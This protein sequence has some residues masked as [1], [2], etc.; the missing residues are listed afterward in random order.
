M[1][2][3]G[4]TELLKERHYIVGFIVQFLYCELLQWLRGVEGERSVLTPPHFPSSKSLTPSTYINMFAARLCSR[5]AVA[6]PMIQP[7]AAV[8]PVFAVRSFQTTAIKADDSLEQAS[9]FIGAGEFHFN[10]LRKQSDF[11]LQFSSINQ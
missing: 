1:E 9:K 10:F 2:Y 4:D 5:V 8:Q 7:L 11:T 3:N 6:R